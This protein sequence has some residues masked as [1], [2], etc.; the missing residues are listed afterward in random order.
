MLSLDKYLS[1]DEKILYQCRVSRLAFLRE[2]IVVFFVVLVSI[3]SLFTTVVSRIEKYDAL[4]SVTIVLFYAFLMLS[5]IFLARVEYKIWSKI[6][7]LTNKRII[8]S[9]GIFSEKFESTTY[10]KITDIGLDQSFLDK[11]VDIG[12]ISI[13]TVGTDEIEITFENVRKPIII[14]NKINDLQSPTPAT[15][16]EAIVT[17]TNKARKPNKSS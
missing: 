16:T 14:K 12:T 1:E 11:I 15:S 6:Y 8:V 5:I 9:Q 13:D 17:K 3:T 4:A 7:A 2:Y 10:D